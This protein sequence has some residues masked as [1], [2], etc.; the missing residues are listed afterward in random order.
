MFRGCELRAGRRKS[1]RLRL[2]RGLH[3][4]R[5]QLQTTTEARVQLFAGESR[6]GHAA[7]TVRADTTQPRRPDLHR[8]HAN[9]DRSRYRLPRRQ[10]LH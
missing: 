4:R 1:I 6:D 3:R 2:Q 9:G 8:L 5:R 7:D 10:G